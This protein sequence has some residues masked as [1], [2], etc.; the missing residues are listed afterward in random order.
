[1]LTTDRDV[2]HPALPG[3][4]VPLDKWQPP[5]TS[6]HRT[7]RS[8]F[9]DIVGQLRPGLGADDSAFRSLDQLPP[10]SPADLDEVAPDPDPAVLARALLAW[11]CDEHDSV[12]SGRTP[13]LVFPPFSGV[14]EALACSGRR[15][16]MPPDRWMP[17]PEAARWWDEVLAGEPWVLPDLADFWFCHR[18]G[19]ALVREFLSRL[20]LDQVGD[21]LV[22]C[23]GWCWAF[24]TRYWPGLPVVPLTPA[25]LTG[26]RLTRWLSFLSR[27]ANGRA[28]TARMSHDGLYV[29]PADDA[30][31]NCRYSSFARDLAA[32]SRG[33]PGVAL[34][35]WRQ[36]LRSLPDDDSEH[37]IPDTDTGAG[38]QCWVAPLG[39]ASLPA[40]PA[41]ADLHTGH[42]L[43][44][45]LLHNGLRPDELAVVTGLPAQEVRLALAPLVRA[46]LAAP[47]E[48]SGCYRV[49]PLGYPAVRRYLQARG[50]LLD[51]F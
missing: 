38:R 51:A 8:A 14:P 39:Q 9:L 42:V 47:D 23:S 41:E 19:L 27:D 11:L 32:L 35:I 16:L 46:G 6:V 1:V 2:D 10:L 7:L 3:G 26:E 28:V 44:A 29:L 18:A 17:E 36:Q 20:A 33:N 31:S 15:I 4:L 21:G 50:Y 48:G 45:L 24:W 34:A 13:V 30:D 22:G 40:L 25:P 37:E 5:E 12:P 43:H 49:R